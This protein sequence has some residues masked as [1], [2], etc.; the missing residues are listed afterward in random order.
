MGTQVPGRHTGHVL[1][2]WALNVWSEL[3]R[4]SPKECFGAEALLGHA[5]S[6]DISQVLSCGREVLS[7]PV[8][9][10]LVW[11]IQQGPVQVKGKLLMRGGCRAAAKLGHPGSISSLGMCARDSTW[12]WYRDKAWAGKTET[13]LCDN[14]VKVCSA[15]A[16]HWPPGRRLHLPPEQGQVAQVASSLRFRVLMCTG[17]ARKF[18]GKGVVGVHGDMANSRGCGLKDAR[19][20]C[21]WCW[22]VSQPCHCTG[23]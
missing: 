14:E 21:G 2:L 22:R 9:W 17:V 1:P 4:F 18:V 3:T 16:P 5:G 6:C 8:V 23:R 20:E 15:Q 11:M 13:E 7:L 10:K 12:A 19:G